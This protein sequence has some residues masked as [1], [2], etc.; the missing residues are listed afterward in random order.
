MKR[1]KTVG[2]V[3]LSMVLMLSAFVP[4]LAASDRCKCG[5]AP[6][7]S[8]T[9]FGH[10]PLVDGNG[11]Q[12]FAPDS[13]K[14]VTTVVRDVVPALVKYLSDDDASALMDAI[15]PAAQSLFDPVKCDSNGN[16]VDPDVHIERYFPNSIDTYNYEVKEGVQ[17]QL[18]MAIAEKIGGD[19]VY[20]F[21][22][23]WRRD[24]ADLAAELNDYIQ[25]VKNQTG[26]SKV[27]ING[28]SMGTCVVQAYLSIYGTGDVQTVAMLS[29]A[30]TGLEMIGQLFTGNIELDGDG[31][32]DMLVQ[33]I[34]GSP[35]KGTLGQ[36][37]KYTSLFSAVIDK[38][39]PAI[40]SQKD[41]IYKEFVV[42]YFGFIPS[43][44]AFVPLDYYSDAYDYMFSD[45]TPGIDL[46]S[47]IS[48][49]HL[50][51][52]LPMKN[53]VAS[54]VRNSNVNYF[55]VSQY[56]RQIAPVTPKGNMNSDGVI[57]TYHTSAFATVADRGTTL[58]DS[59][60]QAVNCHENHIS[61][62]R[63]VDASTCW[64]PENTWFIKNL[65]HVAYTQG[66]AGFFAWLMTAKEQYDVRSN[67]LYTQFM[68]YNVDRDY[69]ANYLYEY[70]DVNLDGVI[71]LVDARLALR[72]CM[73]VEYLD[74][75]RLQH[76]DYNTDAI[77]T[78]EE[79]L[80]IVKTYNGI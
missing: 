79:V 56:N 38:L 30:Y 53:R 29:G 12:V 22:Y 32:V 23:D 6:V 5:N 19:H 68:I 78:K 65:N 63:V 48:P 24:M 11:K 9:G 3:V 8:V 28:Q 62:D 74:E 67:P 71:D 15:I 18:S 80:N 40:D 1:L 46:A 20:V 69:L 54:L 59:Y 36:L 77:V 39:A 57:E 16:S 7:I 41:R 35:D 55:C 73:D 34:N 13:Q 31:L 76:A 33:A 2:A 10:V 72:H 25:N 21:T 49:Y 17:D 43:I 44:W 60:N 14:I 4:V 64:A 42:P 47:K 26:H 61:P 52:Q 70:G 75:L 66:S 58:S 37:L 45:V 51:V 50:A 27:A